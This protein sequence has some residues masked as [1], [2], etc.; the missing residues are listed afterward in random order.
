MK[1]N[2]MYPSKY[3]TADDLGD[4]NHTVTITEAEM[5]DLGQ[6]N[7][8][9]RKLLLS[10]KEMSKGLI[11]NKTNCGIIAKVLGSDDTEDW[12]GKRVT[13]GAREVDGPKGPCMAIR[14][15]IKSPPSNLA[16]KPAPP[17]E[18][19]EQDGHPPKDELEADAGF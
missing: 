17:A 18:P 4:E 6:G 9:E 2:E 15:S 1:L 10:L 3:L 5:V 8:K 16:R 12:I 7:D 19:A 13:I 14:V 11:A